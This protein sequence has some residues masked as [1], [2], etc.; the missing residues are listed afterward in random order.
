[1]LRQNR[2]IMRLVRIAPFLLL[3]VAACSQVPPAR[4][5][6]QVQPARQ[7]A[8]LAGTAWR[9]AE[10]T[11]PGGAAALRPDDPQ[12]YTLHFNAD[13]RLTAKLDCNRGSGPWQATPSAAQSGSLRIGPVATTRAMCPP[14][15]IGAA[16]SRDLDAI[17]SYRLQDGRLY[18]SLPDGATTYA[19]EPIAP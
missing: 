4:Q 16:L 15:A 5:G 11:P 18:T 14:D 13:G 1:M 17:A 10:V 12:R 19:W 9:L 7:A 8:T 6:P 2:S 3:T